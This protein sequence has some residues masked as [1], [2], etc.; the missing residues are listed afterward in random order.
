MFVRFVTDIRDWRSHQKLG[1][2]RAARCFLPAFLVT[3]L[4]PLRFTYPCCIRVSSVANSA[5][6][7]SHRR[8]I[9]PTVCFTLNRITP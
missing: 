8:A 6:L 1:V 5:L 2:I 4:C 7:D 3:L 9:L